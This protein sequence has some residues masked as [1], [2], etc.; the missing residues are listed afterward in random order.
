LAEGSNRDRIRQQ[1]VAQPALLGLITATV[2]AWFVRLGENLERP[3]QNDALTRLEEKLT[4]IE[5]EVRQLRADQ[6]PP[7]RPDQPD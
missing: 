2:A 6:R 1:P 3:A 4:T 7:G 5:R